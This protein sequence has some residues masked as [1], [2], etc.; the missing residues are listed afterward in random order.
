MFSVVPGV[1]A[2]CFSGS[3]VPAYILFT[4]FSVIVLIG[5]QTVYRR[6]MRENGKPDFRALQDKDK[7]GYNQ[8][9]IAG[10]TEN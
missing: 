10:G 2:D 1:L 3:Y 6:W 9:N 4:V 8:E 7:R 5:V